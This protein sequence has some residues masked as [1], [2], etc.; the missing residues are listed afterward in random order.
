[1]TDFSGQVAVVTGGASG[2]G[3]AVAA[4]FVAEGASVAVLDLDKPG[5]VAPHGRLVHHR[6]DVSDEA[7]VEATFDRVRQL[8]SRI[9]VVVHAAAV[10]GGSGPF[11]ELTLDQWRRYIDVNLTGSFLVARAAATRMIADGVRGRIVLIGSVNSFAAERGAAPYV[12]SKGGVRLLTR[13]AAVDLA[14]HGITVNMIAPGPIL[15][16][17]TRAAFETEATR[18][19]LERALPAGRPG[20]PGDVAAAALFLASPGSGFIT[21]TDLVV[22]GGMFAQILN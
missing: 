13:A 7:A 2:I 19:S 1:M 3:A 21:G 12:A 10:L 4:A 17:A 22:D 14:Q 8:W 9:D 6:C 16:P 15:T 11:A 18:S 5:E 20:S